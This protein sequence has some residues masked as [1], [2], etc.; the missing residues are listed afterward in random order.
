MTNRYSSFR[1]FVALF[2]CLLGVAS[3]AVAQ[4]VNEPIIQTQDFTTPNPEGGNYDDFGYSI[5]LD[6]QPAAAVIRRARALFGITG[7]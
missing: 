3:I 2:C 7:L 5:S 1:C 6:I 4:V